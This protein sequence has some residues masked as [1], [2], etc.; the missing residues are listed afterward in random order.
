MGILSRFMRKK[1]PADCAGFADCM[2]LRQHFQT[3]V[4][5]EL[6]EQTARQIE[7]RL[8]A[9]KGCGLEYATYRELKE[10]L[11]RLRPPPNEGPVLRR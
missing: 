10:S 2:E 9:C 3:H 1:P 11:T 4:D 6:D 8:E 5:G 7:A